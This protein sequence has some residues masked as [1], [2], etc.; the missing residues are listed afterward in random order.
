MVRS[1][2]LAVIASCLLPWKPVDALAKMRGTFE[3]QFWQKE[4]DWI[5]SNPSTVEQ[6]LRY[7]IRIF[8]NWC[9]ELKILDQCGQRA[10]D[11]RGQML[12]K[13]HYKLQFKTLRQSI[14]VMRLVLADRNANIS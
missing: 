9:Q 3:Y 1:S 12:S 6:R 10:F 14:D 5:G 13:Y 7:N 4:E 8:E 11:Q 2:F